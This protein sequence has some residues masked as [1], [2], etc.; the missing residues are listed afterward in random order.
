MAQ[1]SQ[2][3]KNKNQPPSYQSIE[4]IVGWL[5]MSP[6]LILLCLFLLY[7]FVTA[8][9]YSFTNQR[10]ISPNPAEFV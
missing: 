9:T 6:A 7:P 5:M 2:K 10:L 3:P 8:F 1:N 4:A